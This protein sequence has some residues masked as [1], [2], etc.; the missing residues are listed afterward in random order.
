MIDKNLFDNEYSTQWRDEVDY[1]KSV[2]IRYSFVKR[3]QG[4]SRY[5]YKKS[6]ELF[7]Q[8]AIFYCQRGLIRS[9]KNGQKE[10]KNDTRGIP[11][12]IE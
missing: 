10:S 6:S 4:I 12:K 8:L 2:G 1:L 3:E 7:N 9:D 5:K 11:R